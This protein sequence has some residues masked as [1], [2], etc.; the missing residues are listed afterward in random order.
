MKLVLYSG[1]DERLNDHL[2]KQ[3]IVL[4]EKRPRDIKVTYIPSCSFD[5]SFDYHCFV[6]QQKR[7]GIEKII[8]F[9]VDVPLSITSVD[10]LRN[11]DIIHLSGGNTFYFLKH[12]RKSQLIKV[13]RS[14]VD[15]GG[16]LTGLSAGAIMMTPNIS[17]A[18]FPSFDCDDNFDNMTNLKSLNL[19]RFE[20]FPHFKNSKRYHQELLHY[21]KK[22]MNPVFACADGDGIV[23]DDD[24][25]RFFGKVYGMHRGETFILRP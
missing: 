2:D 7:W 16:V 11:S 19:C 4:T 24:S 12:L 15:D 17:T 10:K 13:L 20:F 14:F 23:I 21:S 18:G 1:G 25:I 5:S 9:P 6:R 22:T 8:Y 3:A